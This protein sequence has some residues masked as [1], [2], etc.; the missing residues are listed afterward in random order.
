[1]RAPDARL[2]MMHVIKLSGNG[3]VMDMIESNL[4]LEEIPLLLVDSYDRGEGN[5]LESPPSRST[6][7]PPTLLPVRWQ[8]YVED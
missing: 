1:M 8:G 3:L 2:D 6:S 4:G 7:A 5:C